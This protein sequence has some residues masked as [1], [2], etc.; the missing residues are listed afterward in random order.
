MFTKCHNFELR[1]FSYH[2]R[3][4][5]TRAQLYFFGHCNFV[6]REEERGPWERGCGHR[7]IFEKPHCKL[8]EF[9]NAGFAG[10]W[11]VTAFAKN[12]DVTSG[13]SPILH[14]PAVK[15]AEQG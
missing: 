10:E 15:P 4:I 9:E 13:T 12:D 11:T 14:P 8:K 1:S 2:T 7:G 3:G 6:P 5:L